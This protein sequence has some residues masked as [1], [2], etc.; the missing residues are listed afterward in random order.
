MSQK[1]SGIYKIL[2]APFLYELTQ[3]LFWRKEK[4]K[5]FVEGN[6]KLSEGLRVLD[7]GCGTGLLFKAITE[8]NIS[9]NYVGL[10]LNLSYIEYA[11]RRYPLAQF[12]FGDIANLSHMLREEFDV[13]VI[14]NVLH[15][16]DD[17]QVDKLFYD[18]KQCLR[19]NGRLLTLDPVR[20]QQ[21]SLIERCMIEFDRG[22][23]I[24][25]AT[26]YYELARKSFKRI[27][28][29]IRT[30]FLKV[31]MTVNILECLINE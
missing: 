27:N 14:V 13:I 25:D 28:Q 6:F 17:I 24:R 19:K 12:F 7:I 2:N 22:E 1:T 10:D 21:A 4:R 23:H 3:N 26:E 29:Q 8:S 15:H 5:E 11:T 20:T 9:V 18:C 30:G 16:L 31:P